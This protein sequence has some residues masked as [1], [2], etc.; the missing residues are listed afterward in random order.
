MMGKKQKQRIIAVFLV[1]LGIGSAVALSLTALNQTVTFFYSPSDLAENSFVPP[2]SSNRPF[3]LGGLVDH[4]SVVNDG[5]VT[6]FVVTDGVHSIDVRYEGILPDLF[7]E[8]QG[9]VA[10]G[11]FDEDK[12]FVASELLAKHDENYMPPEVQKALK[13]AGHPM[14]VVE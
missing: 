12:M 2:I 11:K 4:G 9:V 14:G 3:R 1:M 7:K 5:I 13:D 8:G 6:R 10:L